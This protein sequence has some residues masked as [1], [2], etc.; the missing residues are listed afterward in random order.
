M[1]AVPLNDLQ[2]KAERLVKEGRISVHWASGRYL[3]A[4]GMGT[5][6]GDN[7]T[8]RCSF[9]PGMRVCTCK[10]G[11]TLK[12][13][14]HALALELYVWMNQEVPLQMQLEVVDETP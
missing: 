9:T 7:G 10:A 4:A 6:V 14:S 5:V 13:C 8:Y 12:D 1:T 2:R 3:D 11:R